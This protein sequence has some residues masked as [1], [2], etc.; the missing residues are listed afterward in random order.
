MVILID[1]VFLMTQGI[2]S[3]RANN[4]FAFFDIFISR[5]GCFHST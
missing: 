4:Q 2:Y 5:K 3:S 1:A